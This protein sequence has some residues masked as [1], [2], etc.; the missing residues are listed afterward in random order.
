MIIGKCPICGEEMRIGSDMT[1]TDRIRSMTDEKLAEWLC[2]KADCNEYCCAYRSYCNKND[3]ACKQ[4]WLEWL[5][6]EANK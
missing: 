5:K 4:A 3:E 1:N 2:R 6:E